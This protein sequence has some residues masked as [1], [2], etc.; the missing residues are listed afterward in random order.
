MPKIVV[1]AGDGKMFDFSNQVVMVTGASGNLGAAVAQGFYEAGA[2]LA[3]GDRLIPG[4]GSG[5]PDAD[6]VIHFEVDLT[7]PESVTDFASAVR[8]KFGRIDVLAN[9]VGGFRSAKVAET[10]IDE[11]D[12]M[13]N[14]N[15]RSAFLI[16]RAVLPG[17]LEQGGG[18]IVHTAA[19]TGL[20]GRASQAAYSA[21][22][23][24][25]IR[26]VESLAAEVRTNGIN[27]NCVLPGTID[28]PENRA[29]MPK[30]DFS[31]WVPPQAI[32]DA[33][34]FLASPA[35]RAVNGAALPVYGLS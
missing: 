8:T 32:A 28:T 23:S 10:S 18:K 24:G 5:F 6:R 3:L 21:A 34:L 30:A 25:V 11:W 33:I 7:D 35:A 9:T 17:M 19:R 2:R 14:L 1:F 22:K 26:L 31:R 12:D 20:A 16:T 15:T 4:G 13:H 27:I 29:E